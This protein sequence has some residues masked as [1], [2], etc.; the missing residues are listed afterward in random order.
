MPTMACRTWSSRRMRI[1][2]RLLPRALKSWKQM[3]PQELTKGME[4]WLTVSRWAPEIR[5]FQPFVDNAR[6]GEVAKTYSMIFLIELCNNCICCDISWSCS[7]SSLFDHIL[8]EK[9]KNGLWI[10]R[11]IWTCVEQRR[12]LSLFPGTRQNS[13]AASLYEHIHQ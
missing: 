2:G 3:R 1:E 9:W 10:M 11:W 12:L 6:S 5:L 8:G 7:S 13:T 4:R